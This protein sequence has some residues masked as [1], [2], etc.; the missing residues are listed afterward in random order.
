M[1]THLTTSNA[2][3]SRRAF[4]QLSAG[5]ATLPLVAGS[6]G[7]AEEPLRPL[8]PKTCTIK[9][10][11]AYP[12]TAELREVG[13]Y[14]WPGS[15]FDAE[16]HQA[17]YTDLLNR[18]AGPLGIHVDVQTTILDSESSAEQFA[19]AVR[20]E[21]PDGLLLV[22]LKKGHWPRIK[23][24]ADTT[25]V[26][27]V[28]Y[29]PLGVLLVN[30]INEAREMP[31][32]YLIN[33]EHFETVE[34]GLRMVRAA[35]WM[36]QSRVMNIDGAVEKRTHVPRLGTEILTIPHE[37][38]F[39][40]YAA[41]EADDAIRTLADTYVRGAMSAQ[42]PN[43]QDVLDAARC[44]F[45]LRRMIDAN[46]ADAVMMNC[47]PGL[48]RPHKHVPPCMGF[49]TLR[50]EGIP[51]GCQSDL[52]ATLTLL[53]VQYL[54]ERP[55]FQQNA[56]MDTEQNLY[57]GAHCT[58]PSRMNG[59]GAPAEP[60]ILRSHAEAG[61]GC[62]PRVL[63]SAGEEVTMAQYL[64]GDAPQ[65]YVYTGAIVS[66]PESAGGCRSNVQMTINEVE[67]VRNVKGMHQIIFYGNHGRH[68]KEFCQLHGI[69][70]IA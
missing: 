59:P 45:A 69:E 25:E 21:K 38:F 53:L 35:A 2:G 33:S 55:G 14:S 19:A 11:F 61:W 51:A 43:E 66:C 23:R 40:A 41:T 60:Y 17:R 68:L 4:M 64:S 57:F 44:Y 28:V 10:G 46:E 3:V 62:V 29:A 16:G 58:C 8:R 52:N 42:E 5:A 18:M 31:G 27:V 50:D 32:V 65:M 6:A 34:A 22:L 47:L 24:I 20:Q 13:Y 67:D 56:S 49:M 12:P 9:C 7:L 37:Q 54:F 26:P 36:G 15:S 70:A 1:Q 30:H 39:D 48:A 63:L